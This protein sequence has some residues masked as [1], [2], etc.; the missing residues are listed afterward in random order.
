M[1]KLILASASPRRKS[2]LE[3][4]GIIPSLIEAADIDETP[5][6]NELPRQYAKR[7]CEAKANKISQKYKDDFVI[8][9]DTV[10]SC[11][12]RIL[13]KAESDEQVSKCLSVLSGRQHTVITSV[14]VVSSDGTKSVKV[15]ET[16]VRMKKL[17]DIQIK[18]YAQDGEGVGK[19]GGYAIQGRAGGFVKSLNGSYSS[20]VGLPL[21]ETIAM[22]EGLGW[23]NG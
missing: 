10:V 16:K 22:L 14:C 21:C 1:P 20:V 15:V 13:P 3:Q 6:K 5:L 17:S 11:G 9:A 18:G 7:I 8:S 4:V 23:K 19:A 2:L 12:R